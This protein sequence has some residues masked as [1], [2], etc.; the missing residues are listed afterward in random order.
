MFAYHDSSGMRSA[1][2]QKTLVA[3]MGSG[4][5]SAREQAGCVRV[6]QTGG[7]EEKM[8]RCMAVAIICD[9]GDHSAAMRKIPSSTR[10]VDVC[11]RIPS[12]SDIAK[13]AL[14]IK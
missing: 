7:L 9:I 2:W 4:L 11:H 12:V 1:V 10:E 6:P 5:I 8:R 14:V 13:E 3:L